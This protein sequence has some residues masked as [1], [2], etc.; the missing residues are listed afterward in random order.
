ML[1]FKKF[2]PFTNRVL[3][4]RFDPITKSKGGI[5]LA[6]ASKTEQQVGTIIS[7]GPGLTLTNGLFRP[8]NVKA[9]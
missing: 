8:I 9:G 1:N 4:K 7:T 5:I 3:I 2:V 6:D